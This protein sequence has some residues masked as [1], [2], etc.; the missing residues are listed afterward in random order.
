MRALSPDNEWEPDP[1]PRGDGIRRAET[2]SNSTLSSSDA[3]A[4]IISRDA[5]GAQASSAAQNNGNGKRN[6]RGRRVATKASSQERDGPLIDLFADS[7]EE[8]KRRSS[9][10]DP[11]V[12]PS[13]GPDPSMLAFWQPLVP[14]SGKIL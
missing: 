9:P 5:I 8:T 12:V 10:L 3:S 6:K 13:S 2:I 14:A 4:V 1:D 11:A 7:D